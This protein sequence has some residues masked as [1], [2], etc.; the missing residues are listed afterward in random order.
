M[1]TIEDVRAWSGRVAQDPYGQALGPIVGALHD[2][3]TG[4]PEWL[5]IA[6][7]GS[8]SEGVLVPAGGALSTGQRVRVV[9]TAEAVRGAPRVH[10][11][12]DLDADAKRRAAAHYGL[13][14]D[15]D[16]SGSGALRERDA[17]RPE[18]VAEPARAAPPAGSAQQRAA[19]VQALRAA[20]A[21]EQMS[22][23]LL[24]A[25]RWRIED[26][27][28]VHDVAFHHKAT[29]RHAE[30]LRERLDELG[31]SRARPLEWAAKLFAYVQ[32]QAG[33]LRSHPDP[34][35][36][37]QAHAFEQGEAAAYGR[38]EQVARE[39]GDERTAALARAIRADEVAMAMTIEASA[40]WRSGSR[41][42]SP[43]APRT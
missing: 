25:M 10:V 21:M 1:L 12:E 34:A 6:P 41:A 2:E 9:P 17:L 33:R 23:K 28:L 16:A 42:P 26:E 30:L 27:E 4:S 22:L 37:K 11:G 19:V 36:L 39:A 7:D 43:E 8:E 14:L 15:R 31:A 35:D 38:I 18:T 24:A 3:Q 29:N 40:L 5:L 20:H 32:A 13:A